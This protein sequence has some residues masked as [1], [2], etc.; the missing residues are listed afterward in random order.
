MDRLISRA[1]EY[2]DSIEEMRKSATRMA[3]A[4]VGAEAAAPLAPLS[5]SEEESGP[6]A[7]S[8]ETRAETAS[9]GESKD[10]ADSA[11]MSNHAGSD[12]ISY[13][14]LRAIDTKNSFHCVLML[15]NI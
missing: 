1:F 4:Q 2:G 12:I 6:K 9:K 8:G 15:E 11:A 7:K 14:P 5:A 3:N 10:S 13:F